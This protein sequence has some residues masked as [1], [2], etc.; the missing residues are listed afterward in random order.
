MA[1]A[2]EKT[3][4]VFRRVRSKACEVVNV[5]LGGNWKPG[6]DYESPPLYGPDTEAKCSEWINKHCGEDLTC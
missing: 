5:P 6:P 2:P 4:K 3:F 1:V